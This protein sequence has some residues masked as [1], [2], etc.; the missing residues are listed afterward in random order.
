MIKEQFNINIGKVKML[1]NDF[2]NSAIFNNFLLFLD[3]S[4]VD[5]TND[6]NPGVVP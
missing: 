5:Y 3:H 1:R 6:F 2:L 4:R